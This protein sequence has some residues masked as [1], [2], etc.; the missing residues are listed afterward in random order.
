M[1]SDASGGYAGDK[2]AT[3]TY[4]DLVDNPSAVLID[5]RT[6][7]E[8]TFVG[9]PDIRGLDREPVLVEW[10]QFQGQPTASD[11]V[12]TLGDELAKRGVEK[13]DPLYFLCRSGARSLSA[14]IAMTQAGFTQ[15]YNITDGFEGPL[16]ADGHRGSVGGWK[17]SNLPW[18]QS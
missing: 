8:W 3:A 15:C 4:Q 9:I 16:D 10:Q 7:A 6:R 18:V 13:S 11:F 17:Q 5:V 1:S 2:T 14:A 12:T